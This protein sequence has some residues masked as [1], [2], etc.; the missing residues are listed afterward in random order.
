M[1]VYLTLRGGKSGCFSPR[2]LEATE[3]HCT[4]VNFPLVSP[5][6]GRMAARLL[7]YAVLYVSVNEYKRGRE[8]TIE[9][10][11]KERERYREG[12]GGRKEQIG[13]AHV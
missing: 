1:R 6:A 12:E 3:S 13:R 7:E 10:G 5:R 11:E 4:P 8:R 2:F 9:V